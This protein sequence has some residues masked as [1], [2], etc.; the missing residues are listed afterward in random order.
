VSGTNTA[1]R[2]AAHQNFGAESLY[3]KA[4]VLK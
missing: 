2:G 1:G 3:S 4:P